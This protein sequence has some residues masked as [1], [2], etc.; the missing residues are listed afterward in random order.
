MK[1]LKT[2][3]DN[4][5]KDLQFIPFINILY[6]KNKSYLIPNL[7]FNSFNHL[8]PKIFRK[9]PTIVTK[10]STFNVFLFPLFNSKSPPLSKIIPNIYIYKCRNNNFYIFFFCFIHKL[11]LRLME[12]IF[13]CGGRKSVFC[14]PRFVKIKQ[15]KKKLLSLVIVIRVRQ[16]HN[17]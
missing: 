12:T 1:N 16:A 10:H 3:Q 14:I 7:L 13:L 6:K 5:K 15:Y 4:S 11:L 2:D 9:N 8:S 17:K